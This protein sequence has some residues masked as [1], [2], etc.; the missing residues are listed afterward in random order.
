MS[1]QHS[2]IHPTKKWKS[3]K[4]MRMRHRSWRQP[5]PR[6][7]RVMAVLDETMKKLGELVNLERLEK[8]GRNRCP[9]NFAVLAAVPQIN[10]PASWVAAAHRFDHQALGLDRRPRPQ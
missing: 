7:S 5:T 10:G 2:S 6:H 3:Q 4:K 9:V 1:N 8:A